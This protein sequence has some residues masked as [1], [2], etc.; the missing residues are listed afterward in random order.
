MINKASKNYAKSLFQNLV[1]NPKKE[2]TFPKIKEKTNLLMEELSLFATTILGS[3]KLYSFFKNPF[4]NE[5]KKFEVLVTLFPKISEEAIS[6]LKILTEKRE[7]YLIPEIFEEYQK[8]SMKFNKVKNVK[9]IINSYLDKKI[10][11]DLLTQLKKLTQANEIILDIEYKEEI[12]GGLIIE[13]DSIA[14]DASLVEEF[15]T[16][17]KEV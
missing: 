6:L 16:F 13:C 7:L 8:L 3:K 11:K 15:K 9:L 4:L 1:K 2:D 14:L 17:L 10:G 5:N 12:L